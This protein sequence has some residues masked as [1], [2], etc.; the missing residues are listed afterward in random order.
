MFGWFYLI[1]SIL[2]L[3]ISFPI[4]V[5]IIF[6]DNKSVFSYKQEIEIDDVAIGF[7]FAIL[8]ALL[9][10]AG[11]TYFIFWQLGELVA[12]IMNSNYQKKEFKRG[13]K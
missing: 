5:K 11:I 13:K 12:K 10:P 7:I 4:W 6:R 9:W 3:F 1:V 2:T 8:T